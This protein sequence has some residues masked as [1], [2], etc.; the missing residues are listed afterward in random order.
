MLKLGPRNRSSKSPRKRNGSGPKVA[1]SAA[2]DRA[3][4]QDKVKALPHARRLQNSTE[5]DRVTDSS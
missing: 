2:E 4:A 3:K 1:M 5:S